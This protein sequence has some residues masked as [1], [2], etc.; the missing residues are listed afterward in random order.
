MSREQFEQLN[1][2]LDKIIKKLDIL[3]QKK[4]FTVEKQV[5]KPEEPKMEKEEKKAEEKKP[6]E[7]KAAKAVKKK[8]KAK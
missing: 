7:K 6:V 5:K 1:S 4:S 8:G 3:K 2:K